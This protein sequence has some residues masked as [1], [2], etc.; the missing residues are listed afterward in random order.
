MNGFNTADM[1]LKNGIPVEK[2]FHYFGVDHYLSNSHTANH[3]I[4]G[5]KKCVDLGI[6]SGTWGKVK[7]IEDPNNV[8]G[9]GIPSRLDYGWDVP[10]Q[11]IEATM[12]VNVA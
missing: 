10:T 9:L 3:V 1:A 5:V 8:S 6:L 11:L 4:A 7:M 2:A 12:D